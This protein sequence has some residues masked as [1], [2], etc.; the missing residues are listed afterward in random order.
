MVKMACD[1]LEP[2]VIAKYAIR[3]SK[4]FN[5]Y[6]AHSKILADDAGLQARL[7]LVK[8]VSIVVKESLRLLGVK[9]PDEM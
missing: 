9:A 6:Y 8:S 7:A 2:S 3:L 4:T 1:E 5:K